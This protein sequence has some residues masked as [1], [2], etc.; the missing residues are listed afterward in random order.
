[1]KKTRAESPGLLPGKDNDRIVSQLVAITRQDE[2]HA[3]VRR[4][5]DGSLSIISVSERTIS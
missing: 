4:R 2:H 1:M 5:K 3:K